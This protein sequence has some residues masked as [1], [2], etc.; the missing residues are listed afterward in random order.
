MAF[1]YIIADRTEFFLL[2]LIYG[3]LMI[4]TYHRL[5]CRYLNNVHAIDITELLLFG[6][7][8]TSHAGF[9]LKFIKKILKR[10]RRK[11]T[12]LT[13]YFYM[14]FCLDCLMKAVG[15]AASRHNTSGKLIY[16]QYFIVFY[17]IIFVPEHQI[18]RTECQYDIMLD[19]QIFCISQ[20]FDFKELLYLLYA[21]CSQIDYFILFIDDEITVF[22]YFD[23]HN[24]IHLCI[25][26]IALPALHLFC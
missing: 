5:I 24:G 2:R 8:R 9:F 13:F 25:F 10:N 12:A 4:D 23:T 11:R 18:M 3:I 22:F 15:I 14:L 17:N 21:V 20:I 19:F 6:Q 26:A 7:S 1:L 16:N